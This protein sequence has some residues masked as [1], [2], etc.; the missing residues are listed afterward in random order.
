[1]SAPA[2]RPRYVFGGIDRAGLVAGLRA[3]QLGLMFAGMVVAV[4]A[5]RAAP[6]L[7]GMAAG[8]AA[9]LATLVLAF[10][11][12]EGRTVEQWIPVVTV[13]AARRLG[14]QW[15]YRSP[16]PRT[17][18]RAGGRPVRAR[19]P[20]E[21]AGVRILDLTVVSVGRRLGVLYDAREGTYAAV[22]AVR[23][24]SFHLADPGEVDRRLSAWGAVLQGMAVAGTDIHRLQWVDRALPD[25]GSAM[26][27]Y[28]ERNGDADAPTEARASYAEVL[29]DAG[30]VTQQHETHLVV[31]ISAARCRRAIKAAGGG[32]DGAAAVVDRA[33]ERLRT[34][35]HTADVTLEHVLSAR[36]IARAVR[37]SFDPALRG[38]LA[39]RDRHHLND[40]LEE[41]A[42]WPL[43]ARAAPDHYESDG[44]QHTTFWVAEWPRRPV[45]GE[46]MAWLMAGPRCQ[47]T[48]AVT[49]TPVDPARA[50]RDVEHSLTQR[51]ADEELRAEKGFRAT[52]RRSR[53]HEAV[54]RREAE[55][56]E[57]HG[58]FRYSAYVTVSAPDVE[59]LEDAVAEVRQA[60]NQSGLVLARLWWQQAEAFTFTLPLGRG[61]AAR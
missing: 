32:H 47:V 14:G 10:V 36:Q 58:D 11:K 3:G 25:D 49:M 40:G 52:A 12:V 39:L 15:R 56:A 59:R 45:D 60:A 26:Q 21:A 57:G 50:T 35:L 54:L 29:A 13:G 38:Q 44:W 7:R 23:G 37:T 2:G 34:Q 16:L 61:V 53:E 9:L 42:A 43:A 22:L 24:R 41:A 33:V 18:H 30:P 51:V 31:V 8:I 20:A 6:S 46:F 4:L 28:Y 5:L 17:G 1:M 19:P 48:V 55:L 27:S